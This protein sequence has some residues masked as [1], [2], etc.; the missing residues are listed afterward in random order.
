MRKSYQIYGQ[1]QPKI[2]QA[3]REWRDA[4][5]RHNLL[6]FFGLSSS[7]ESWKGCIWLPP[8]SRG[9]RVS[10]MANS[11]GWIWPSL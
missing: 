7:R 6:F 8:Q 11:K 5:D 4:C 9:Q 1:R 3:F 2:Q 10:K